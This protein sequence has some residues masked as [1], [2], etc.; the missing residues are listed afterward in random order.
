MNVK[1]STKCGYL[2]VDDHLA[3]PVFLL[4]SYFLWQA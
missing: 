4:Q 3:K 2:P 1:L